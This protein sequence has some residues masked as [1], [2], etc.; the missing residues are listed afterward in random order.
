[1]GEP[2]GRNRASWGNARRASPSSTPVPNNQILAALTIA[3][4]AKEQML[5]GIQ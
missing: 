4:V 1:V 2:S 3:S 5:S